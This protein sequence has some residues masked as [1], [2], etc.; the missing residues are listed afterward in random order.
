[1]AATDGSFTS[2]ISAR[3]CNGDG[4]S[5]SSSRRV[6][7]VISSDFQARYAETYDKQRSEIG[8]LE[9]RPTPYSP[10]WFYDHD[11]RRR[12]DVSQPRADPAVGRRPVRPN[13]VHRKRYPER[14]GPVP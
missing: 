10:V 11:R 9:T 8:P 14:P 5:Q 3:S 12:D 4:T 13:A 7:K 2:L 1:M 6:T